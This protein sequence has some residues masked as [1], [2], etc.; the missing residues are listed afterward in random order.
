[1]RNGAGG[2]WRSADPSTNSPGG[3][4]PNWP[5]TW[6]WMN[7]IIVKPPPIVKAPTLRKY[8]P[9]STRLLGSGTRA[10]PDQAAPDVFSHQGADSTTRTT[11]DATALT[12]SPG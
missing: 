2:G 8:A 6:S 7:A 10:V 4:Q 12:R 1:M 9:I 11:A 3:N 5:T